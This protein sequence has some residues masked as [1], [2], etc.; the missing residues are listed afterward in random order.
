MVPKKDSSL[1]AFSSNFNTRINAAPERY[2]LSVEQAQAYTAVHQPFVDAYNVMMAARAEGTRSESQTTRKE[3]TKA[4]L[5][6]YA[7]YLYATVAANQNVSD[8]DKVSLGIYVRPGKAQ[9][10]GRP[11]D[12]PGLR[13]ISTTGRSVEVCVYDNSVEGVRRKPQ[14]MIGAYIYTHCGEDYPSDPKQWRF[15][16]TAT[17]GRYCIELSPSTPA[18]AQVWIAAAWLSPRGEAGPMCSPITT[19]AQHGVGRAA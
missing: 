13:L 9:A 4:K 16:G 6:A 11:T 14:G 8:E 3:V 7:R 12:R 18:G 5:Q 10:I 1:V 17:R 19:Y 15:E 2:A